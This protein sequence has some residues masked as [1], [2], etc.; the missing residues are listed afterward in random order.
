MT[1]RR[2]VKTAYQIWIAEM[3]TR[4]IINPSDDARHEAESAHMSANDARNPS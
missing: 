4:P 3:Q 1:N 2:E